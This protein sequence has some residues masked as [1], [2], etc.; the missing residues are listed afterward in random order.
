MLKK[1]LL[2]CRRLGFF[3]S[4]TVKTHILIKFAPTYANRT[5][6]IPPVKDDIGILMDGP[7]NYT[8][9]FT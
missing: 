5:D 8:L 3:I 4:E 1:E 6:F 7:L 2:E 9:L